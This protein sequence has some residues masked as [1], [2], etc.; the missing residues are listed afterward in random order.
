[1]NIIEAATMI[2]STPEVLFALHSD[3]RQRPFWHDHVLS[4]ELLTGEPIGLG[5][6]FR[7]TNKTGWL[8]VTTYEQITVYEPPHHYCYELDNGPLH[9]KSCQR[10]EAIPTGTHYQLRIEMTAKSWLGRI[11]LPLIVRQQRTHFLAAVQELKQ[12]AEAPPAQRPFP[13]Q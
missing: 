12:Y 9:F 10:F 5:S 2:E 7:T 8:T 3:F 4:S 1:M 6:R 11:L 13:R